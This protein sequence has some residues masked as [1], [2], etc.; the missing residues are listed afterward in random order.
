MVTKTEST[1]SKAKES[2]EGTSET[3]KKA[4]EDTGDEPKTAAPSLGADTKQDASEAAS[5]ETKASTSEAA[6]AEAKALT[7]EKG[8]TDTGKSAEGQ[9]SIDADFAKLKAKLSGGLTKKKKSR[10]AEQAHTGPCGICPNTNEPIAY[11]YGLKAPGLIAIWKG[12]VVSR[13]LKFDPCFLQ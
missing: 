8:Q 4:I 5:F 13:E 11:Q 3:E 9:S 1:P 7:P 2:E 12:K 6:S 10:A